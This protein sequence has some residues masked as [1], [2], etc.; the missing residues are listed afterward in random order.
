MKTV[1]ENLNKSK[2]MMKEAVKLCIDKNR[3][4][5]A[6][7]IINAVKMLEDITNDYEIVARS[8]LEKSD[9]K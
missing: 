7:I 3:T 2:H 8:P 1:I 4:L 6:G 9:G 5:Y